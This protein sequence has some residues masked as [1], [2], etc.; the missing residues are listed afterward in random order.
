VAVGV[1]I[2]CGHDASYPF[3]T[4]GVTEG[5]VITGQCG[6]ANYLSAV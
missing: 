1:S 3:K 5:S 2:A 4:T 6:A